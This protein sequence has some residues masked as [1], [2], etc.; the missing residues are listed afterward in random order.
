MREKQ[1]LME[2]IGNGIVPV[3]MQCFTGNHALIETMGAAGFDYVWLDSE[4]SAIDPRALED[5]MRTCE[6]AGLSALVRIPDPRDLTSARRSLE[7]GAEGV[8]VP[9]VRTAQDVRDVI[10]AL[11]FPPAGSRG[12]CPGLR[13]PG[14]TVTGFNDYMRASDESVLVIPMIETA[15]AL[16]NIEEIFALEQV[17]LTVFAMG[18]L[19][20]AMG[21]GPYSPANPRIRAAQERVHAAAAAAGVGIIGGHIFAPTADDL[22]AALDDG[23]VAFCVGIDV[24]AFRMLCEDLVAT[25]DAAVARSPHHRRPAAPASG[26]PRR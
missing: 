20:F 6:V 18:E 22:L 11:T 13:V 8:I 24:M 19:S 3:G 17:H 9:M 1:L 16:E 23:V 26:F 7:A 21:E 2:Q 4:H 25:A 15:E 10:D 12:L 5:T 14:Y